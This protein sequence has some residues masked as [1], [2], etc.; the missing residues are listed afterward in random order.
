MGFD[1]LS[2]SETSMKGYGLAFTELSQEKVPMLL[3]SHPLYTKQGSR[4]L[5]FQVH[6]PLLIVR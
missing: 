2:I 6:N 4:F 1:G 3:E 5:S